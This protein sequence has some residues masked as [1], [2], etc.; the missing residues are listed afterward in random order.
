M[1]AFA[2]FKISIG[3]SILEDTGVDA[4]NLRMEMNMKMN[5]M[6][7]ASAD[8]LHDVF[9]YDYDGMEEPMIISA[10]YQDGATIRIPWDRR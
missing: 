7:R 8:A 1:N 3:G 10:Y 6:Y 5:H 4:T 9:P 2:D